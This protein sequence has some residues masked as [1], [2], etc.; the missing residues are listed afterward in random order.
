MATPDDLSASGRS[1]VRLARVAS[2]AP[3]LLVAAGAAMFAAILTAHLRGGAGV[4]MDW[5][6]ALGVR[7]DLSLDGLAALYALLATAIGTLIGA[8]S[9]GYLPRHL[10]HH[11]RSAA[12]APS[13]YGFI[14]LFMVA[15][16]GLAASQDLILA[17]LF[18]DLT[19][20]CSYLLIG[21]DRH[22]P[23][24]RSAALM[25]LLTTGG[26]A[27][28]LLVA[29][30][31]LGLDA[32]TFAIEPAIANA[33]ESTATLA[34]ALVAV[35]ALAKSAQVPLH[36]WLPRAMAAPTPVSAYLH[37]AA[38][39]AA[40]VLLLGKLHPLLVRGDVLWLLTAV[41]AASAVTG[42]ALAFAARELKQ[43]LAYSTISQYGYVTLLLGLGGPYGA[44]GA[45]LWVFAHAL[46]KSALFLA[47]G[48]VMEATGGEQRLDR[49]GALRRSMPVVAGAAALAAASLAGLPLTAG[50]FKDELLF[51]AALEEAVW[52]LPP[53]RPARRSPSATRAASG[54]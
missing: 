45:S 53:R 4:S 3:G 6:P 16:V 7:I 24:S 17:F 22:E 31:T 52:V 27:L 2:V 8:Y 49:L 48:A 20:V 26:S 50:F 19:T 21:Y 18:W 15:M 34:A 32:G 37:S 38:L 33:G 25:A 9:A 46:A 35:A 28:L 13:F 10:A 54:C 44:L 42:A 36:F 1:A 51:A 40:G 12:E 29:A 23:D 11:G 47:A 5:A 30:L 39:V 14:G 41:G 43:L